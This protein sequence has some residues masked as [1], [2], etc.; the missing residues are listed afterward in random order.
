MGS[1]K[2][3]SVICRAKLDEECELMPVLYQKWSNFERQA[4]EAEDVASNQLTVAE[5]ELKKAV[6]RAHLQLRGWAVVK[7][8]RELHT[9]LDPTKLPT[10][11]VYKDLVQIHPMT[12]EAEC[13]LNEARIEFMSRKA[14]RREMQAA[15]YTM[16]VKDKALKK[17]V[18][19]G[20]RLFG[21]SGSYQARRRPA[22][23]SPQSS[24]LVQR[25]VAEQQKA[26]G[27][28][29]VPSQVV[30]ERIR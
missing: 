22:T 17:L 21:M 24:S 4:C 26:A 18:D 10:E 30:S 7:I 3:D 19:I 6:A 28:R 5:E 27:H 29:T 15:R 20:D 14:H 25:R 12:L 2:D 9:E 23:A 1:W 16:D 8:N 11:Q 13:K